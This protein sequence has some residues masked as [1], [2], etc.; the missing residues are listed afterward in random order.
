MTARDEALQ[1]MKK[2]FPEYEFRWTDSRGDFS[3]REFTID[4]FGVPVT[5]QRAFLRDSRA[6]REG[7]LTLLGS[8][9][10]F[11]F[12]DREDA[13]ATVIGGGG[14]MAAKVERG[15]CGNC[16]QDVILADD[17]DGV[18]EFD[19]THTKMLVVLAFPEIEGQKR[20]ALG[21][22]QDK[23]ELHHKG[24]EPVI[25]FAHTRHQCLVKK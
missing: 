23:G 2:Q 24:E 16:K 5:Q 22:C 19:T 25:Y 11:I 12:R 3:G 15:R 4:V 7:L 18:R 20:V 8:R 9:C 13:F 10:L 1:L 21:P 6:A 14:P 17:G